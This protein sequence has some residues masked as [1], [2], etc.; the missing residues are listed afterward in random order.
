MA[1]KKTKSVMWC[2]YEIN[3]FLK[4]LKSYYKL[5]KY[6]QNKW[7]FI[8]R[9][10]KTRSMSEIQCFEKWYFY[11]TDNTSWTEREKEMFEKSYILFNKDLIKVQCRVRTRSLKE[12]M[13]YEAKQNET[14]L[15]CYEE[16][17]EDALEPI[18]ITITT[19]TSLSFSIEELNGLIE[20]LE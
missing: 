13:T 16:L 7:S 18:P 15:T 3:R 12:V 1:K 5:E 17:E 14:D 4:G 11:H 10:V 6:I 19:N 20:I 8:E 9:Y 2:G